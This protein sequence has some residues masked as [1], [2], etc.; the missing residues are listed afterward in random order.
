[1]IREWKENNVISERGCY[2]ETWSLRILC[3]PGHKQRTEG[4]E[5]FTVSEDC[6]TRSSGLKPKER[7]VVGVN[8][9]VCMNIKGNEQG[10]TLRK[11][12]DIILYMLKGRMYT[13]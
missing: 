5:L 13:N 3:L 1:M 12:K 9:Y 11:M 7:K 2:E 8:I 6:R 10:E 4:K